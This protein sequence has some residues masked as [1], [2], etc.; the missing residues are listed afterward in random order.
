MVPGQFVAVL[1]DSKFST[2]SVS[3][4]AQAVA[5]AMGVR[6]QRTLS[7]PAGQ[8]VRGFSFEVPSGVDEQAVLAAIRQRPDIKYV[9]PIRTFRMMGAPVQLVGG[10]AVPASMRRVGAV[11][12]S[13]AA[14]RADVAVAVVDTG[15]WL[16]HPDLNVSS[17]I[18]CITDG[19]PANDGHGH[20]SHCAGSI[21]ACSACR[22]WPKG[23]QL[24][25]RW[26]S[27]AASVAA[28]PCKA[29]APRRPESQ[30]VAQGQ[31]LGQRAARTPCGRILQAQ[32]PDEAH[33][34]L[35][36]DSLCAGA[37]NNNFGV[38]GVAP[39]TKIYA[40]KVSTLL[41]TAATNAC[42]LPRTRCA[43]YSA[44]H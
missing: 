36:I 15:V 28:P 29:P 4:S 24:A 16:S 40:V 18:N 32:P 33:Q 37:K 5:S 17:G 22:A 43:A 11:N 12:T 27:A 7:A 39:G 3:A 13:T 34:L 38:I 9:A 8:G 42:Q 30:L 26:Y 31:L 35:C 21:G 19:Q 1:K 25:G 20:G 44:P 41:L 6:V 23:A 14:S 2:M 10:Q